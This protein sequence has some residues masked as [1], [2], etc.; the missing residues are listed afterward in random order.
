VAIFGLGLARSNLKLYEIDRSNLSNYHSHINLYGCAVINEGAY[1]YSK[2][3]YIFT[4]GLLFDSHSY[5]RN[6]C[7]CIKTNYSRIE[8]G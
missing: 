6:I 1:Y 4:M 3:N 2:E 5:D 8:L 7:Y